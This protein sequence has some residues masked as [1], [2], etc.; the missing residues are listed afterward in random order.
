MKRSQES[1]RKSITDMGIFPGISVSWDTNLGWHRYAC[2]LE[3]L[4][5][6]MILVQTMNGKLK[7]PAVV[8]I[9]RLDIDDPIMADYHATYGTVAK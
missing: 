2:V 6:G 5:D 4:D 1:I 9:I 7:I 3:I 8:L